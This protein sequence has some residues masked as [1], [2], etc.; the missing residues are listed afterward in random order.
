MYINPDLVA[1]R[2]HQLGLMIQ[3]YHG[4]VRVVVYLGES[5]YGS[6]KAMDWIRE[7]DVPADFDELPS[8]K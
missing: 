1:E 3:I 7:V 6:D 2:N 8:L 4:A 5:A